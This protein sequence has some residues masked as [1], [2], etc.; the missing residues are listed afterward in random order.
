MHRVHEVVTNVSHVL[1]STSLLSNTKGHTT[2]QQKSTGTESSSF[3]KRPK[4]STN[5]PLRSSWENSY[6]MQI[7][8]KDFVQ[9]DRSAKEL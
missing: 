3:I 4:E 9:L 2:Y 6:D 1:Q 5:Q 7:I 8:A